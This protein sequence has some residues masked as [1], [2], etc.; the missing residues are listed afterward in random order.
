MALCREHV[1]VLL[2]VLLAVFEKWV[3]KK[4]NEFVRKFKN[5]SSTPDSKILLE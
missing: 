3:L 5:P 2:Q 1:F 4:I